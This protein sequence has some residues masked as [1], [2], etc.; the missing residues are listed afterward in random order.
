MPIRRN[1]RTV[2]EGR[3]II[4]H[5]AMCVESYIVRRDCDKQISTNSPSI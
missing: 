3:K 2:E 4:V 1:G 5:I